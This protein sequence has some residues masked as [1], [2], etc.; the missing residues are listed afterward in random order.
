MYAP[1]PGRTKTQVRLAYAAMQSRDITVRE[2]CRELGG[3][4][5]AT[6]YRYVSPTGELR[7]HGK[8]VLER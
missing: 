1:K 3:I 7:D 2:L 5:R 4:T 6:L 8:R